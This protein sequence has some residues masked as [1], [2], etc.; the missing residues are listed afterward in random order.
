MLLQIGCEQCPVRETSAI[1]NHH[2]SRYCLLPDFH[3]RTRAAQTGV[4]VPKIRN[5]RIFP[6]RPSEYR[7]FK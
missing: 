3:F 6:S 2:H 7:D 5:H 4:L 1:R